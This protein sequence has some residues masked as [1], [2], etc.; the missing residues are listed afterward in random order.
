MQATVE[1]RLPDR[2]PVH[3]W[4]RPE[5]KRALQDLFDTDD[6][7]T[8]LGI[9]PAGGVGFG[10]S[11]P[12]YAAKTNGRLE[13]DMPHAGGEF[14]FH[15][16]EGRVFE[17]R[18][19]VVR[20]VGLDGKYVEWVRGPLQDATTLSEL[21]DYGFP[22]VDR[23][24]DNPNAA[25]HVSDSKQEGLWV[26]GGVAQPFKTAWELRGLQN[27]LMDYYLNREFL[28]AFYD[29]IYTLETE[30]ARRIAAAG[31]DQLG[32]GGDIAMQDRML[33]PPKLWREIDKPRLAYLIS[34]AKRLNPGIHIFIHSDGNLMEIMDDLIEIGFD[35][36]NP[37]QPEC[38][39]PTEVKQ[40]W[41]DRITLHGTLSIQQTLPFGTVEDVRREV[42]DRIENCGY[43]GGLVI[44]P[45]NVIPYDV[46]IE[47]VV[48]AFQTV[49]EYDMSRLVE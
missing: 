12:D 6:T 32:I 37:V 26:S 9:D 40:R 43:N 41:G 13:G 22:G 33:I 35:I 1:H 14:I 27:V 7:G 15:D 21:E 31:A 28:E 36:I 38:M 24:I 46:P 48:T 29:K 19:G 10:I 5:V 49:L 18:W 39:D 4:A 16:D 42:T 34:E 44:G 47:N 11:F 17:D 45:S 3:F 8:A 20:R 2:F 23:T 25:Q 30:V